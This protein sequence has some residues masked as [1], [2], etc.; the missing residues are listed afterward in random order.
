MQDLKTTDPA[1]MK[2][3]SL[4][5]QLSGTLEDLALEGLQLKLDQSTISG[6][7]RLQGEGLAAQRFD[8]Q[9]DAIDLDRYLPQDSGGAPAA[10]EGAPTP[11]PRD[12]LRGLNAE[13]RL[14]VAKLKF[15]GLDLQNADITLVARDNIVRF[16]PL[17][18]GIFGGTY[19]ADVV[20]D[21]TGD[22]LKVHAEQQIDAMALAQLGAR[23]GGLDNMT[24]T[25]VGAVVTDGQGSDSNQLLGSLNGHLE[26]NA[27]DGALEGVN[28][29]YEV[30]K[31]YAQY[32]SRPVPPPAE[33][34]TP[35]SHLVLNGPIRDGVM[36][37]SDLGGEVQ[38]LS[39]TGK[40]A[41]RLVEKQ[42]D[43]GITAQVRN[44]PEVTN[45][46]MV[47]N[48]VGKRLPLRITGPLDAPKIGVDFKELL[49]GEA[50]DALF[51]NL[52]GNKERDPDQP[53]SDKDQLKDSAKGLLRDLL[54]G[55]KTPPPED[56]SGG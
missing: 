19:R 3:A 18:A 55:N 37:L 29:W 11:L 52:G 32:K 14:R 10:A 6:N 31:A 2:R 24:G 45:D 48:L 27:L 54:K 8:L 5:T 42:L 9:I 1:V 34:R 46:P 4:S 25:L 33:N 40:G 28:L 51:D 41:I 12:E 43:L 50:A 22:T 49:K 21:A 15:S 35:F 17:M 20:L 56:E 30:R 38:V 16:E 39:L 47:A 23:F 26:M 44:V 53:A 36:Q 13:G 7:L